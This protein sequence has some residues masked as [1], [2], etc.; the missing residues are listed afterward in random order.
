[1]AMT[2][3]RRK[4]V[5]TPSVIMHKIADIRGGV[6]ISTEGL[7]GR[8]IR[9]GAFITAPINGVC[10]VVKT[11]IT[12]NE[13]TPNS[14]EIEVEKFHNFVV[15]DAISNGNI[16]DTAKPTIKEIRE[17]VDSDTL[18]LDNPFGATFP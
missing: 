13:A 2:V 1:M 12:L 14:T 8:C 4:E 9:E 11:A 5:K 18:V 15:G 10:H 16:P 6:S 17:G 3:K 7:G